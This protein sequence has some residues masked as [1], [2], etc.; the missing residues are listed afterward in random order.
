MKIYKN[1]SAI[2]FSL[3]ILSIFGTVEPIF[4][5]R[6]ISASEKSMAKLDLT[7][8]SNIAEFRIEAFHTANNPAVVDVSWQTA[9]DNLGVTEYILERSVD[10]NF[11]NLKVY[12][13]GTVNYFMDKSVIPNT[14]YYWR[15]KAKDA[16]GNLSADWVSSIK[17]TLIAPV[18]NKQ[19]TI[20]GDSASVGYGLFRYN[21]GPPEVYSSERWGAKLGD[22]LDGTW[23]VR[24]V[25]EGGDRILGDVPTD[26]AAEITAFRQPKYE[27]DVVLLWAGTNDIY[28]LPSRGIADAPPLVVYNAIQKYLKAVKSDGF[29]VW[30]MDAYKR[31]AF[32]FADKDAER[33]AFNNLIRSDS[34]FA[35]K[36]IDIDAWTEFQSRTNRTVYQSDQTH[37]TSAGNQL[38]AIRIFD[39]LVKNPLAFTTNSTLP[40]GK[41]STAYSQT[42]V[43]SG[44]TGT[45]KVLLVKGKL[46]TGLNLE[47][48]KIAGSPTK[49]GAFSFTLKVKDEL[50][51]TVNLLFSLTIS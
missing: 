9:T 35:D 49:K 51:T 33:I 23:V 30:V 47:G 31:S 10:S 22:M 48:G 6:A 13:L 32:G 5:A 24:T 34:S 41:I 46:P 14:T 25:A 17:S 37:L 29:E 45:L 7:A 19:F 16:A 28:G 42:I 38:V 27:R 36:F 43:A 50:G 44:G 20:E 1:L 3:L 18:V 39:E 40:S 15:I 21:E 2:I 4:G 11:T 26:R 12:N 8:P